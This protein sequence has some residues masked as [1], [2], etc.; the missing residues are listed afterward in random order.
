MRTKISTCERKIRYTT[1]A[2]AVRDASRIGRG[3]VPYR[4][5]RCRKWHLTGIKPGML[6]LTRAMMLVPLAASPMP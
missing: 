5:N 3:L 2:R 6:V 1:K 4:C